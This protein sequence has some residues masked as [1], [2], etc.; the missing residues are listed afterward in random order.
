[1]GVAINMQVT[2]YEL[3]LIVTKLVL[4]THFHDSALEVGIS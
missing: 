2:A 1:M 4:T 3:H